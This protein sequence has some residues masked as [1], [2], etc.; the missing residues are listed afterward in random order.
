MRHQPQCFVV[1]TDL[2]SISAKSALVLMEKTALREFHDLIKIVRVELFTHHSHGQSPDKFRLETVLAE[3]VGR[4]VLKQFVVH[5]AHG[6]SAESDLALRNA[7]RDLLLQ[8]FK[9]AAHHKKNVARIDRFAFRLAALLK[10]EGRLQLRLEIVRAAHRH[11][12]F[13]HELEQGCLHTAP[14]H[15][16]PDQ[17]SGRSDLVDLV[18]V[19]NSDLRKIDVSLRL[20]HELAH[21]VFHVATDISGLAELG[22]VRLYKRHFDQI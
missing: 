6:L 19:N 2:N 14:A 3:I 11:L 13:F 15:V 22:R 20:V 10:F 16:A 7:P 1:K 4:A 8:S 21:Q 5:H 9:R 12:G 17:V 18:D